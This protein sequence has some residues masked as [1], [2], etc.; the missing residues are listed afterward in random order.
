L[1]SNRKPVEWERN[2]RK[3][4]LMQDTIKCSEQ[5]KLPPVQSR[6]LHSTRADV[7]L[8]DVAAPIDMDPDHA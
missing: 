7:P 4:S 1:E 8:F 5:A 6:G 2:T 3:N